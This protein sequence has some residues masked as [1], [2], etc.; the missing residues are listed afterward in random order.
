[1]SQHLQ[2]LSPI[3]NDL[4]LST[5]SDAEVLKAIEV[6]IS[7]LKKA[8]AAFDEAAAALRAREPSREKSQ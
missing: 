1:M 2:P 7:G 6:E 4:P 8:M 3:V 5:R